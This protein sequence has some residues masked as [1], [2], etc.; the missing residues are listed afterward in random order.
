MTVYK[1]STTSNIGGWSVNPSDS[2]PRPANATQYA[3]GDLIAND[4]TAAS[5]VPLTFTAARI[6]AGSFVVRRARLHKD[7]ADITA[8]N[9]RLHLFSTDPTGTAPTA[10]DNGALELN[11]MAAGSYLGYFDFNMTSSPD[12]QN[13]DI[14]LAAAPAVG[15]DIVVKLSSGKVI[16]GLLEARGTYTPASGEVFTVTLEVLQD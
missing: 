4:T 1:T 15:T 12:I 10:G 9:F 16:Y 14:E 2:F 13:S 11:S 3:S 5:V 7:D 6:E 8:A